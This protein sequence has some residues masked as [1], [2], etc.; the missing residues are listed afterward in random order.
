MTNVTSSVSTNWQ[1]LGLGPELR[2]WY[3]LMFFHPFVGYSLGMQIGQFTTALDVGGTLTVS[4]T[5]YG[6]GSILISERRAAQL[7][8]HRLMLG[9]EIALLV[10]DIGVEAQVD[11]INGLVG[12]AFATAFR[13]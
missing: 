3:N 8:T 1:Y 6:T 7:V 9:F 10:L 11:L 12:G 5:G 4:G 13:F 2:V